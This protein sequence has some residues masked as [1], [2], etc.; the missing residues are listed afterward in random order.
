MTTHVLDRATH[1]VASMFPDWR[2]WLSSSRLF[3]GAKAKLEALDDRAL[4]DIGLHRTEIESVL[5]D[6]R[7]RRTRMSRPSG[8]L[9]RI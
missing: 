7:E 2:D 3:Q 1:P 8:L 6:R 4:K 9:S 5:T